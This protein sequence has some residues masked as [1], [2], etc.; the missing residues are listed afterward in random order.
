PECAFCFHRF[1]RHDEPSHRFTIHPPFE[2]GTEFSLFTATQ[3][4]RE[5]FVGNFSVCVY[6]R[7][8]VDRLGPELFEMK[9]YDWMFNITVAQEGMIGYI[10][11][12]MSVYRAHPSGAWSA[13][14]EEEWRP[15]LLELIDTYNKYLGFKF[16]S[17][18]QVYKSA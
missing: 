17:E 18:F 10:P 5:N 11:T 12:V 4:A 1:L 6:R 14:P 9:V 2:I 7:E 13:K 8:V 15:E 16:D 3:L